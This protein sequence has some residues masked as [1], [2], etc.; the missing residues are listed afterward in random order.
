MKIFLDDFIVYNDMDTHLAKFKLSFQKCKRFGIGMNLD[1][2][3]FMV[4][5][6]MIL[7]FK[8]SNSKEGKISNLNKI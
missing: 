3:V 5:F 8:V 7:G 2:C 6:R 1:K 4:F